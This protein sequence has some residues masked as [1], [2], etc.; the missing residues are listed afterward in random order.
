MPRVLIVVRAELR[1]RSEGIMSSCRD[2]CEE[3]G[4]ALDAIAKSWW[5][6]FCSAAC[7]RKAALR[8]ERRV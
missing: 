5:H 7:A 3:C 2:K 6:S 4:K 1:V 8:V